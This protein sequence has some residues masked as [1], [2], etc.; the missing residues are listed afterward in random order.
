M[1][2]IKAIIR[3]FKLDNVVTELHKIEELPGLTISEIQGF[4]RTKAKNATDAF[5]YGLHNYINR[6]KIEIVVHDN[7]VDKVV[8]VIQKAAHTGN[9]G[10]GKIFIIDVTNTVRIR[11]A[12]SGEEAI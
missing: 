1:K 3:P 9:S 4:G 11:T 7:L 6:I 12:E 8:E 10:D 5:Q 2:E